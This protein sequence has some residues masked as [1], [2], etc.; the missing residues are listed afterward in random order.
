MRDAIQGAINHLKKAH[1]DKKV[2]VIITDGDDNSS[3]IGLDAVIKASQQSGV[4]IYSVGL[5]SE[6]ERSEAKHAARALDALATATG[7][8]TFFPKDVSEVERIAHEVARDI[9]S[10]YSIVYMPAN[11][12]M[13]GTFRR[14]R[15][16]AKASGGPTVRTR[17]GYYATPDQATSSR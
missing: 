13:D 12:A 5:L 10:Q 3:V 11:Q 17:S 16:T 8:E 6:E 15:V 2:L 14:I 9:R 1:K 7:G 4:L